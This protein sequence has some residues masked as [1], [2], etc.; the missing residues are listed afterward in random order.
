MNVPVND[1]ELISHPT[2]DILEQSQVWSILRDV[3]EGRPLVPLMDMRFE[4][5][6]VRL[7]SG[8]TICVLSVDRGQIQ[9][10]G[11]T[12]PINEMEIELYSGKEEGIQRL[13]DALSDKYGLK[14]ENI[15]K[16]QRGYMLIHG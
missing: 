10:K 3:T 7:D 6:A 1:Q 16:F 12:A 4:R 9:V 5:R 2:V 11:R 13:G 14:P 8:E 15:S